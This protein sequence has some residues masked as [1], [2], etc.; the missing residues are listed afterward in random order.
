MSGAEWLKMQQIC[1][2]LWGA[3]IYTLNYFQESGGATHYKPVTS[4]AEPPGD[5]QHFVVL[6]T[7][8]QSTVT[9]F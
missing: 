6:V 8:P 2:I 5:G 1:H 9:H 4:V 3:T 7:N